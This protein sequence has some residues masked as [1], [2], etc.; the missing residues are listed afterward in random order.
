M[1]GEGGKSYILGAQSVTL[2]TRVERARTVVSSHGQGTVA[3]GGHR[4]TDRAP[5]TVDREQPPNPEERRQLFDGV[6][7]WLTVPG[8]T[9]GARI[10]SRE[11]MKLER[12]VGL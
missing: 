6:T 8:G 2:D 9:E 5:G 12:L 10:C 7:R 4:R 1:R 3:W 11:C